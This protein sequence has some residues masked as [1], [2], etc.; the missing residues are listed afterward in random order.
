[1]IKRVKINITGRVQGVFFRASVKEKADEIDITGL[2]K[3]NP[4]G[5]VVIIAEGSGEDLQKLADWCK[6]GTELSH[7]ERVEVEWSEASGQYRNFD[8]ENY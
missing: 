6:K 4:D 8:A 7:V 2:V 1:M 5:S 3:N